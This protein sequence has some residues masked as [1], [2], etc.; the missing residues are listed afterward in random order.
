MLNGC[1]SN[2]KVSSSFHFENSHLIPSKNRPK[3]S[4]NAIIWVHKQTAIIPRSTTTSNKVNE[5]RN[6]GAK[7]YLKIKRKQAKSQSEN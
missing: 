3:I 7:I 2:W 4:R 5:K 6:V 1:C